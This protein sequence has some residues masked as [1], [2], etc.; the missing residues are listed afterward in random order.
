MEQTG[1]SGHGAGR[2]IHC[3][4]CEMERKKKGK[5]KGERDERSREMITKYLGPVDTVQEG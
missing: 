2:M 3:F 4:S 1:A 5:G